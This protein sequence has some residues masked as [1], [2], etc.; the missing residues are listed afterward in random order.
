MEYGLKPGYSYHGLLIS[1]IVLDAL[2]VLVAY[3][4]V[5]LHQSLEAGAPVGEIVG[6]FVAHVGRYGG[7][8]RVV[9]GS[10][11]AERGV[12]AIVDIT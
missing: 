1:L 6:V 5:L 10:G 8:I 3:L 7:R 2:E 12:V 9:F 11:A 4:I